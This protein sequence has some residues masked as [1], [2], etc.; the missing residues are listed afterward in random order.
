MPRVRNLKRKLLVSLG[1]LVV[2][3]VIGELVTRA[4]EPGPFS[5]FDHNPYHKL[6]EAGLVAR[7]DPGFEGRWDGT[8]Y[9]TNSLGM[10]GRELPPDGGGPRFT[11]A[12]LG[13]SCTFGKGV[14]EADCWPRQLE[15]LLTA[16]AGGAWTPVVANLGVNGYS[17]ATYLRMLRDLGDD[18]GP[19]VVVVGYNLNDFPNAIRAVNEKVFED[20]QARRLIPVGTRDFLGRF[21]LYRFARQTFYHLNRDRDWARAEAFAQG[22]GELAPDVR[23]EQRGYLEA[24]RNEARARDAELLVFLFPYESQ[25]YLDSFDDGPIRQLADICAELEVPFFDVASE[26]RERA[27]ATDPPGRLFLRGDRYHP[28]ATGYAI[29]AARVLAALDEQEWLPGG[30]G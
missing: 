30:G 10:R 13:D 8:W 28:N 26:F 22:A 9:A 18:V 12:C 21:A 25:V 7:H 23:A 20:R 1:T 4:L 29:V 11:V 2:A 16:R 6:D 14:V 5:L 19:D 27:R 24:L 3:L 17:G 15:R